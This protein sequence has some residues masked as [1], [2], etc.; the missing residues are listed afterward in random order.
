MHCRFRCFGYYWTVNALGLPL[1]LEW[2][3]MFVF[4]IIAAEAGGWTVEVCM[5]CSANTVL[6]AF[7]GI[8]Q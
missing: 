4:L 3:P 7:Q 6:A 1:P 2:A 5:A 8:R